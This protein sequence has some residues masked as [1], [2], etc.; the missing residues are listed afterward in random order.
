MKTYKAGERP[1]SPNL[2]RLNIHLK[3]LQA[4]VLISIAESI[5]KVNG[6]GA[7]LGEALELV[8]AHAARLPKEDLL[9]H[10][11]SDQERSDWTNLAPIQRQA[12]A[13]VPQLL[14]A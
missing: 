7:R 6:R 11:A 10:P 9:K 5:A 12:K 4:P 13:L 2:V 1:S 8:L 14:R 3:R